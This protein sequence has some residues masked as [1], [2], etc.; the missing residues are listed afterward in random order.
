MSRRS[1]TIAVSR[2]AFRARLHQLS[3]I[4]V[5]ELEVVCALERDRAAEDRRQRR[6]QVVRDGG[7]E[8]VL[9]VVGFAQALDG[10][11]FHVERLRELLLG[12]LLLGDVVEDA[13]VAD[14][15]ARCVRIGTVTSWTH[16]TRP[17][18]AIIR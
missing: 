8:R 3:A 17:S 18:R 2:F 5:G 1:F 7:E 6:T 9:H 15:L 16:T 11:A 10:G 12:A 13:L 14:D 4:L